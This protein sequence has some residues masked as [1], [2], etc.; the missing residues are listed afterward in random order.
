MIHIVLHQPEIPQNTG[1]IARTC[2]VTGSALHLIHPLGFSISEKQ[3]RRAGLDYWQDLDLYEYDSLEDFM[4]TIDPSSL[5]AATTKG[6]RTY[7]SV[8]FPEDV[9][10][11]FGRESA[12]LPE[13]CIKELGDHALRI[14]MGA[15]SRSLNLSNC[16][17][18]MV[19]EALRQRDFA[20]LQQ[21]G[22]LH[23]LSW[24]A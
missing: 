12:G 11:L 23:R 18:I 16:A 5:F 1:N 6:R 15:A 8:Q 4:S 17:A 24:D 22:D 20:G 2:V 21:E 13:E 19:Y 3:V 9:Y 14:P 7:S 10:F